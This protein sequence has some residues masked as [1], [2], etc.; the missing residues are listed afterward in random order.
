MA[1]ECRAG[2][3]DKVFRLTVNAVLVDGEEQRPFHQGAG[4]ND[5]RLPLRTVL[6][7]VYLGET[8]KKAAHAGH[9]ELDTAEGIRNM[10][11]NGIEKGNSSFR[12][13]THTEVNGG[14]RRGGVVPERTM[15]LTD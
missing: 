6:Q 13:T 5:I 2:A 9:K 10:V 7:H 1:Q 4:R 3:S 15:F 12:L 8:H 11:S 14:K